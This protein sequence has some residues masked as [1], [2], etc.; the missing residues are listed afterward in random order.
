MPH[1][2]KGQAPAALVT[3][4]RGHEIEEEAL[5]RFTLAHGPAYAHPR[6][7][8]V[9]NALPVGGTGKIDRRAVGAATPGADH[10]APRG[11]KLNAPPIL[12][13]RTMR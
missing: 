4:R 7:V 6:R 11:G 12:F 3:I 5:K 1:A 8:F 9:V 13:R 2:I 10:G